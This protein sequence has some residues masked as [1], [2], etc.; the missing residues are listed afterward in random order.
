MKI[1]DIYKSIKNE[2]EYKIVD[3]CKLE[4]NKKWID[5]V[6]VKLNNSENPL[7]T[8]SIEKFNKKFIKKEENKYILKQSKVY[9]LPHERIIL[10]HIKDNDYLVID[11]NFDYDEDVCYPCEVGEYI[12]L[13]ELEVEDTNFKLENSLLYN[14]YLFQSFLKSKNIIQ[15][16]DYE[17]IK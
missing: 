9:V 10:F 7:T 4:F 3:F 15:E 2:L 16:I 13:N 17:R 12:S 11:T 1:N 8:Y 5:G 6:I 14:T